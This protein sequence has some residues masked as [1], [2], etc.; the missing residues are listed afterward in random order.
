MWRTRAPEGPAN[1]SAAAGAGREEGGRRRTGTGTGTGTGT[2]SEGDVFREKDEGLA[3]T[4]NSPQGCVPPPQGRAVLMLMLQHAPADGNEVPGRD[5][6]WVEGVS[7]TRLAGRESVSGCCEY[8]VTTREPRCRQSR[9]R[10]NN[11]IRIRMDCQH[12]T[13]RL[14]PPGMK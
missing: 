1:G 9:G 5:A 6:G 4:T 8:A 2:A 7:E 13:T 12:S 3:T 11:A 14:E 10:Q